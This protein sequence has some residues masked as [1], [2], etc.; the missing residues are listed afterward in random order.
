MK[1]SVKCIIALAL[2]LVS[3]PSFAGDITV[4]RGDLS[5]VRNGANRATVIFDY[6]DLILEGKPYMEQLRSR[7]EDFV[8]D[9]PSESVAS[10][11]YFIK[12]FNK[13][14]DDG[15][16][17]QAAGN[18]E[19]LMYFHVT[20][21]HMG[22]G[23]A[24]ILVGFGAGGASMSGTMYIFKNGNPIPLLVVEIDNQTGRSGMTEIVR[25]TDLYGELAEDLVDTIEKT[26]Q[27]KVAPSTTPVELPNLKMAGNVSSSVNNVVAS[28][29]AA[30][31][32]ASSTSVQAQTA[33]AAAT[34]TSVQA[35]TAV[36]ASV[37][38]QVHIS[39]QTA[40]TYEELKNI[41]PVLVKAQSELT[42]GKKGEAGSVEEIVNEKRL[43]LYIDYS[44]AMMK[45]RCLDDFI[46]VMETSAHERDLDPNFR[47]N[48]EMKY[49]NMLTLAFIEKANE[50]LSDEDVVLRLTTKQDC[51]YALKV[52]ALDFDDDGNNIC[53]YLIVRMADGEVIAH[54]RI[55]AE[56]G[57]RGE[58][59]GLL[60]QG[61]A[62]AGAALGELLG[63]KIDDIKD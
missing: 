46:E 57:K 18:N 56:G 36:P 27:S 17:V 54:Y 41:P 6:T 38:G 12:C 21:M 63:K 45:N 49:R 53:D 15:M 39:S 11:S 59:I 7:G 4:L 48:W 40:T 13:D 52:V 33:V 42:L 1:A 35:Q 32:A 5:V 26:K 3:V 61:H 47:N 60:E 20:K 22:S 50:A 2:L 14:N 31:P 43:G 37:A 62:S 34:Q 29:T 10:E 44:E 19:Y 55:E 25:R 28:N 8:R 24:S 58:Y 51:K 9:W 16:Q 23:A 30:T